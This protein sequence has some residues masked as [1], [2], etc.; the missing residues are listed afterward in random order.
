MFSV[1]PTQAGAIQRGAKMTL[2]AGQ[3]SSGE[4][5]GV[6]TVMDVGGIVDTISRGVT[7]RAQ[8]PTTRRPLRIGGSGRGRDNAG[9]H[10]ACEH[11]RRPDG[12]TLPGSTATASSTTRSATVAPSAMTSPGP[13]L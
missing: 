11:E 1:T 4:P 3:S 2:S 7:I 6:G 12:H 10:Q 13:A 8:A 9:E 5:L